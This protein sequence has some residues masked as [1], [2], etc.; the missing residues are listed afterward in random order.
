MTT[1]DASGARRD[2]P[3]LGRPAGAPT[4]SQRR[5]RA[6]LSAALLAADVVMAV[7]AFVNLQGPVRI[8]YGLAFCLVVPGWSI[9]GLLRLNN[10]PLEVGLT[11]AAGPAALMVVAQLATSLGGWHLLFLQVFV[12]AT[13]LPAL[14]WQSL[15]RRGARRATR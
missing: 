13:C 2:A 12:C 1:L 8:V 14:L 6:N 5:A 7:L 3:R 11:M 9:V 10:P 4:A 15:D